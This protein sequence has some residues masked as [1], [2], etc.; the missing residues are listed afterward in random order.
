MTDRDLIIVF[1]TVPDK[2]TALLIAES[3][4]QKRLA[5][6]ASV[7]PEV[8]SV[9]RWQGNVERSDELL[10]MI[11]TRKVHFA[12]LEREV[13]SLHPYDTPEVVSVSIEQVLDKYRLWLLNE[14]A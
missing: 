12:E 8:H 9:Y 1:V 14:T 13:V 10:L 5:A 6:C 4:V 11:K 2:D 7:L 3:L